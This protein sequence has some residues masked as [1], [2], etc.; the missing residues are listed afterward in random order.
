M[1]QENFSK[2]MINSTVYKGDRRI[3]RE[4][5]EGDPMLQRS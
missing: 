2:N 4:R 5:E 1:G 3:Y